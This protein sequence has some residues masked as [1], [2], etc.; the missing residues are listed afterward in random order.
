MRILQESRV[1]STIFN[2]RV[3]MACFWLA[4]YFS[5]LQN[6]LELVLFFVAY[7]TEGS[8]KI[9]QI[10]TFGGNF[11]GI[12]LATNWIYVNIKKPQTYIS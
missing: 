12:K 11:S 6:S 10:S 7:K 8:E 9:I 2:H 4:Y 5:G 3:H 1:V